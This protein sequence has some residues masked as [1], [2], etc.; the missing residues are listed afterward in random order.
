MVLTGNS[1]G[2]HF[3]IEALPKGAIVDFEGK[4]AIKATG[5]NAQKALNIYSLYPVTEEKLSYLFDL[6]SEAHFYSKI[7]GESIPIY[8]SKIKDISSYDLASLSYFSLKRNR[9]GGN[10]D[11]LRRTLEEIFPLSIASLYS[12]YEKITRKEARIVIF[13]KAEV[14]HAFKIKDSDLILKLLDLPFNF[15]KSKDILSYHL[16]GAIEDRDVLEKLLSRVANNEDYKDMDGKT[17]LWKASS[18]G[19]A[20]L[21][22]LLIEKGAMKSSK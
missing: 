4:E 9:I 16:L 8:A 6:K 10:E 15:A 17:L 21:V 13:P 5:L 19:R 11:L 1:K 3:F 12:Y 2:H 7:S 20:A 22:K 18:R 14:T